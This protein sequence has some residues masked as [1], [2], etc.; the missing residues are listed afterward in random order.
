M[1]TSATPCYA[2]SDDTTGAGL[3]LVTV[4][5]EPPREPVDRDH[6]MTQGVVDVVSHLVRATE[7]TPAP[8][9]VDL[10]FGDGHDGVPPLEGFVEA[11]RGLV[12]SYVLERRQDIGPVNVVVSRADQDHDRQITWDYLAGATGSFSRGATYDLREVT[13]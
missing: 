13:S 11:T 9:V 3:R 12:Q 2:V 1:Q 10:R 7:G 6:L 8:V 5:L 4:Q